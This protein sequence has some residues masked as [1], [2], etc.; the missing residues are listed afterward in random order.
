[1]TFGM[2]GFGKWVSEVLLKMELAAAFGVAAFIPALLQ[3]NNLNFG[4]GS[5][6]SFYFIQFD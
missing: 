3:I 2:R 5:C 6:L 1:M 4:T